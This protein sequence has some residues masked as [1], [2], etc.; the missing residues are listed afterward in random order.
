M[1]DPAMI[2]S[3]GPSARMVDRTSHADLTL[4]APIQACSD[5]NLSLPE[6]RAEGISAGI[7]PSGGPIDLKLMQPDMR[8]HRC[9]ALGD[10]PQEQPVS[11]NHEPIMP[12]GTSL[13]DPLYIPNTSSMNLN[14]PSNQMT[15]MMNESNDN[16]IHYA[17]ARMDE[18][19]MDNS[20]PFIPDACGASCK[21][22]EQIQAVENTGEQLDARN[23]NY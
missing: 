11:F 9:A 22:D 21:N 2:P 10:P 19:I 17:S 20:D 18:P 5:V 14:E 23:A 8:K 4:G 12:A 1:T 7:A 6:T 16:Y 15:M 3:H 13:L